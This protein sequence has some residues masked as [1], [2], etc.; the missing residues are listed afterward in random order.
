MVLLEDGF[1]TQFTDKM[2]G[3]DADQINMKEVKKVIIYA[4]S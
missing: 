3:G 4:Y 1:E 2:L